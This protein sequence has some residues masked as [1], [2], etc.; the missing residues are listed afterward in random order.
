MSRPKRQSRVICG[1]RAEKVDTKIWVWT[2]LNRPYRWCP[3]GFVEELMPD[4]GIIRI[5]SVRTLDAAVA[6][7]AGYNAG[8]YAQLGYHMSEIRDG[9]KDLSREVKG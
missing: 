1:I 3:I 2:V 4:G 7:T 8:L 9:S 5:C 6:Y